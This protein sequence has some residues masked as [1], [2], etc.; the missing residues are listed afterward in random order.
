MPPLSRRLAIALL[1]ALPLAACASSPRDTHEMLN[2]ALW[3]ET[4]T[5]YRIASVQSYRLAQRML[6]RGLADKTWTAAPEQAGT[7]YA[8]KPPAVIL[9]LDETVLDNAPFEAQLALDRAAFDSKQWSR[10]I[11][12]AQAPLVPGA[13]EFLDAAAKRQVKLF[14]VTNRSARH[15]PATVANLAKLGLPPA[16]V[17]AQGERPEWTSD[18]TTRRAA[19]ARDYRIVLLIGDQL[20]D[21][22][23]DAGGAPDENRRRAESFRAYWG[24]RWIVL[25]NPMYGGWEQTAAGAGDDAEKLRNKFKALQGFK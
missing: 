12:A 14:F 16:E 20:G 6:E 24:E 8:A 11:D 23:S 18:K 13:A 4:S 10:W 15:K 25:P 3:T 2:A 17:M 5:E 21:F 19:I 9:D 7:D 22:M 1:V